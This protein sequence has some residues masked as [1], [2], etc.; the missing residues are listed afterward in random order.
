MG[1]P[2]LYSSEGTGEQVEAPEV[3]VEATEPVTADP[4]TAVETNETTE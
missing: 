3:Q 2:D 1:N 4:K